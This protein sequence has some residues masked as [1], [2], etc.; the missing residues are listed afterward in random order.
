MAAGD[1]WLYRGYVIEQLE[2][3]T[4]SAWLA[5]GISLLVF[6]IVHWP[7]LGADLRS[8]PSFQAAS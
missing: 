3:L 1:E 4:G 8:Q 6:T 7:I 2:K 5:G